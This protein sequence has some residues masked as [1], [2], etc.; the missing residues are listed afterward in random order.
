M[1]SSLDFETAT[2]VVTGAASGIGEGC[3][4]A[5]LEAG[6]HVVGLDVNAQALESIAGR[7][8]TRFHALPADVRDVPAIHEALDGLPAP[9]AA[10][11]ILVNSAGISFNQ[12]LAQEMPYEHWEKTID[13]NIKGLTAVTHALLPGMVKRNR[14]H[15]VN[16]GSIA[17][18]HSYPTVNVYGATKA[19]ARTFSANLRADLAGTRVRVSVI[20]PGPVFTN[21]ALARA[22]GD[23]EKLRAHY[24]KMPVLEV[25][26]VTRAVLWILSRPLRVQ[27]NL[28]EIVGLGMAPGPML[29]RKPA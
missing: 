21:I 20:E 28:M 9:F 15:I 6:A 19:F 14:G 18:G 7:Y 25:D 8:G 27:V 22:G 23:R 1:A 13:V 17:G 29:R 24:D 5:L 16:L 2:A 11:T 12:M 4:L 3:A 10:P 26:D